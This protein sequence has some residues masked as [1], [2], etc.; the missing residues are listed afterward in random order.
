MTVT[1]EVK[2]PGTFATG[3]ADINLNLDNADHATFGND[4]VTCVA[5]PHVLV[6]VDVTSV[7]KEHV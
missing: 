4:D 7:G 6:T 3:T 1:K 5:I 2:N